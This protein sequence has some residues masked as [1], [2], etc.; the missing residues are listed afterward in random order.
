MKTNNLKNKIKFE[1]NSIIF[2]LSTSII[3]TII[4]I[5]YQ[6][7]FNYCDCLNYIFRFLNLTTILS[8]IYYISS[9]YSK[10]DVK[11]IIAFIH[12]KKWLR[13]F[14]AI[15]FSSSIIIFSFGESKDN[16]ATIYCEH[17]P[18]IID[19]TVSVKTITDTM[20][21]KEINNNYSKDTH[22]IKDTTSIT[23]KD[24]ITIINNYQNQ[25][26]SSFDSIYKELNKINY[27]INNNN[28]K[29]NSEDIKNIHNSL[30]LVSHKLDSLKNN[31]TQIKNFTFKSIFSNK[32]Y[33]DMSN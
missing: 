8:S 24:L 14:I 4:Q 7:S 5:I 32:V 17:K 1:C 16:T 2:V 20:F 33:T 19:S 6:I 15:F 28:A 22:Y 23:H 21:I 26:I 27:K 31:S 10:I 3:L 13:V 29:I 9:F 18:T 30:T 25:K 11:D 12:S